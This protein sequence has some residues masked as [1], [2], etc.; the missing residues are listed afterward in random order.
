METISEWPSLVWSYCQVYGWTILSITLVAYIAWTKVG[1]RLEQALSSLGEKTPTEIDAERI[2][3][4]RERQQ[5]LLEQ[6]SL[7]ARQQRADAARREA[8][9]NPAPKTKAK[10]AKEDMVFMTPRDSDE[11]SRR[12]RFG[13]PSP[14]QGG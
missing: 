3:A 1:S 7:E 8:V 4:A 14:R 13:R 11:G 9:L 10:V 5:R 2:A 6:A 12:P